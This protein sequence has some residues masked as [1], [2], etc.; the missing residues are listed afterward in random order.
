M[1]TVLIPHRRAARGERR[2]GR[3]TGSSGGDDVEQAGR[4]RED[5]VPGTSVSSRDDSGTESEAPSSSE[6]MMDARNAGL[7]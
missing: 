1:E 4:D 7:V 2:G 3:G 5:C 6:G